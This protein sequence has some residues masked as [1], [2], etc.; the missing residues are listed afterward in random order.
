MFFENLNI[1]GF[2]CLRTGVTFAPDK[3]NLAIADNEAGKSTLIA[4]LLAAF[5]GIVEDERVTRDKRP[6]RKNVLPWLKPEEFGLT[7]DFT[8]GKSRWR[9]ERD[10]HQGIVALTDRDSGKDRTSEYHKGRG[11]YQIGEKLIGLGCADFLRSF[12]LKQEEILEIKDSGGL[13]PHVQR[14]ATARDG[15]ATSENAIE[16]LRQALKRYP[17]SSSKEGLTIENALKRIRDDKE[18]LLREMERLQRERDE[19]EPQCLQLTEKETEAQARKKEREENQKL[20]DMAEALE[21]TRLMD[22]QGKLREEHDRLRESAEQLKGYSDFPADR[23]EQ[24]NNLAGRMERL[25]DDIRQREEALQA[26]V[27]KP[28]T[29]VEEKLQAR[30]ELAGVTAEELSDLETA[31][32]RL[33]DR[34][35]RNKNAGKEKER[36]TADLARQGFDRDKFTGLRTTLSS[37]TPEQLR[38]VDDFRA[39]Y[40]EQEAVYRE[41]KTR[42]EWLARERDLIADRRRKIVSNARLFFMMAAVMATVGG[43]MMLLTQGGWLGSVLAGLGVVFAAVG[44]IVQGTAGTLDS[45]GLKTMEVD[46]DVAT[47]EEDHVRVKLDAVGSE[48]NELAT[49]SGFSD[50]NTLLAE[51]G[52]YVR[53][54]KS[55]EPMFEAERN[56]ERAKEEAI[57]ALMQ[58]RPHF[59]R[60]GD[61]LPELDES[62]K[63]AKDLLGRYREAVRMGEEYKALVARREQFEDELQRMKRDLQSHQELAS[64]ILRMARIAPEQDFKSGVAAFKESLSQHH[65]YLEVVNKEL[66]RVERELLPEVDVAAKGDRLEQLSAKIGP[67]PKAT[68]ITHSKE[69]YRDQADRAGHAIEEAN[70]ERIAINRKIGAALE[71]F[72]S[73][74][75]EVRRNL[76]ENEEAE[77]RAEAFKAELE[78]AI[79]VM[80]D[81]SREVYRSWATGLSEVAAPFLEALNPRYEEL[82]F[83]EDLTFEIL[84]RQSSRRIS[85]AE[86]ETVLSSG[87]RDEVFLAARLAISAYLTQGAR[88]PIPV[89]LDEPLAAVD[90]DK[91]VSGMAFFMNTLSRKHQVLIMSCHAERHRWLAERMPDQFGERVH[92]IGL[93]SEEKQRG[94]K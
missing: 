6:H 78:T 34:Y 4:A 12:Y 37:F 68:K 83:N 20:G 45:S 69:Y 11:L 48:L 89:I 9:I 43:V 30:R 32:S 57:E 66:P 27:T 91:F 58:I 24:L 51:Y 53:L 22:T 10:F 85:S 59:V 7:L 55:A 5:Y 17:H 61:G 44:F 86:V 70:E 52:N 90:D 29:E 64:D 40:A 79:S 88:G 74:I 50:G 13:V 94:T 33:S 82:K 16:R 77:E 8:E 71:R 63:S 26:K 15:E 46:L 65:R 41:A 14:V 2:G 19:I 62:V 28:L 38:F 3:V 60:A 21:L 80:G 23:W 56:A 42:M 39:V 31:H 72:Q 73:Q 81:I 75:P 67:L 36:L 49:R 47:T 1:R 93:S 54:E 87:A 92:L 25:A 84:D 35:D 18:S 76:S